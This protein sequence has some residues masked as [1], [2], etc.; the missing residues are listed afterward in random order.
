MGGNQD[1]VAPKLSEEF[2]QHWWAVLI[3]GLLLLVL[4][5]IAI[6]APFLAGLVITVV[7]GWLLI[8][9]GLVGLWTSWSMRRVKGV[10][11][12]IVSSLVVIVAGLAFFAWPIGGL[13]SLTLVLGAYL[14]IDGITTVILALQHRRAETK[15]WGWL[16]M[17]G[18]LDLLLAT[19]IIMLQPGI[20]AWL[21]GVIV[22]VDLVFAGIS[23]IAMGW[24]AK[25]HVV[26]LNA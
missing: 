1:S 24:S 8:F 17:N 6:T 26:A 12:A 9:A 7:V 5:A 11:W 25:V 15:N 3:E 10:A 22:G 2:H 14:T 18:I 19:A 13:I 23:M 20:T 21:V 16:L 4:G